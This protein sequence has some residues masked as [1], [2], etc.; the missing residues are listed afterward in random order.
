MKRWLLE[1]SSKGNDN[2]VVPPHKYEFKAHERGSSSFLNEKHM[3]DPE[4]E[5]KT[6]GIMTN[7]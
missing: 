6:I 3:E 5:N 2:N 4:E 7:E 1:N